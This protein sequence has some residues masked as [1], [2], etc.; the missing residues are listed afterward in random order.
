MIAESTSV[1]EPQ[2]PQIFQL[3]PKVSAE[4]GAITKSKRNEGQN[5]NFRGIDNVLNAVGP[6]LAKC[7][8]TQSIE[9][10]SATEDVVSTEDPRGVPLEVWIKLR[11][12]F[13]WVTFAKLHMRVTLHAPDGSHVSFEGFGSACDHNGDKAMNKAHSVA[14]KYALT[15]GL[16]IPVEDMDLDD[17]DHDPKVPE[18]KYDDEPRAAGRKPTA[19]KQGPGPRTAS[20]AA[21]GEAPQRQGQAI[22]NTKMLLKRAEAAIAKATTKERLTELGSEFAKSTYGFKTEELE[23]LGLMIEQRTAALAAQN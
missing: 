17:P 20:Q 4:I 12:K 3:L 15:L 5:Y 13:R 14:Y 1:P 22:A 21:S 23:E 10:V 6:A 9:I 8:V 11:A 19:S 2:G 7:G 16:C 18:R